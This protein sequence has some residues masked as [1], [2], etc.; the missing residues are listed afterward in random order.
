M[1]KLKRKK[2]DC[3]G[4]NDVYHTYLRVLD[5]LFLKSFF[6]L[7]KNLESNLLTFFQ[8]ILYV[9]CHIITVA[10]TFK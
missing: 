10:N 8:H 1:D 9:L 6:S 7:N 5:S 2:K 4:E 3:A